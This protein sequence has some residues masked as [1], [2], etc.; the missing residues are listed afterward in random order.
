[1]NK[2]LQRF[3]LVSDMHYTTDLSAEELKKIHPESNAS[4]ATGSAF[5]KAQRE[6]IEKVYEDIIRENKR[7][8]LDAVLV[9]GDLSI[10]DYDFRRL[11]INYCMQFKEDCLDRLPCPCF[12]IPGNHDS[13]PND[14]W[15][16]MF[17]TDRE[18]V[19]EIGN[20]AFVMADTFNHIPAISASGADVTSM[21]TEFIENAL[22][23]HKGKNIFICAHY[24]QGKAKDDITMTPEAQRLVRESDDVKLLFR[25][26]THVNNVIDL[27]EALGGKMI[28]D[29]GG[30]GYC[31]IKIDNRYEFN[32]FDK[33]WAWGYQILEI[34]E[35]RISTYH[36]TTNNTYNAVNGIFVLVEE[37][38]EETIVFL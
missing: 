24:I 22:K 4:A 38:S 20:T 9:L 11:P 16:E 13:Y 34:Y 2:P 5:G 14:K 32:I 37:K 25:G 31:G 7:S 23:N 27:G 10:D 19:C 3:L 26:H 8:A 29:I 36:V 6:K 21:N 18:F 28:V 33:K 15:R 12:A 1:M 30:Y 17:G 35:D